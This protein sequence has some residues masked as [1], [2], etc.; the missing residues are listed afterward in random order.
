VEPD[1]ERRLVFDEHGR[2]DGATPYHLGSG[3]DA[4]PDPPPSGW[5]RLVAAVSA[6]VRLH[7]LITATV[8]ILALVAGGGSYYLTSRPPSPDG[9]VHARTFITQ[10]SPSFDGVAGFSTEATL[11]V[12]QAGYRAIGLGI[13]GPGLVDPTAAG[14]V[15]TAS[16]PAQV[17]A[18]ATLRCT[19]TPLTTTAD[20]YRLRIKST[21]SAGD[22][23]VVDLSLGPAG[24]QWRDYV[25]STCLS[26]LAATTVTVQRATVLDTTARDLTIA[27]AL[28]NNSPY[29]LTIS[30]VQ[31]GPDDVIQVSSARGA[32]VSAYATATL[33]A[34]VRLE[35][36]G[37]SAQVFRPGSAAVIGMYTSVPGL[38]GA[39]FAPILT[40]LV[41]RALQNAV[42]SQCVGDPGPSAAVVG[43]QSVR[44]QASRAAGAVHLLIRIKDTAVGFEAGTDPALPRKSTDRVLVTTAI[45]QARNLTSVELSWPLQD[46]SYGAY[47]PPP[48]FHYLLTSH[49]RSYPHALVLNSTQVL[50]AVRSLCGGIPDAASAKLVGWQLPTP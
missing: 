21:D 32:N 38:T 27:L 6:L 15:A 1:G 33:S 5:E 12:D 43:A 36:C 13:V 9:L 48:I 45:T 31:A 16:T 20:A 39:S 34:I 44:A 19:S 40:P 25:A 2:V 29:D 11:L 22:S 24:G 7:P 41:S 47:L 49:G 46:C 4:D 37:R 28:H 26:R 17:L 30:A 18:N 3:N 10:L 42:N 35:D 8:A 14:P 50:T 23:S